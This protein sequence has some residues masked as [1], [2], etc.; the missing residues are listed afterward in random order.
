MSRAPLLL[1]II[2]L[3]LLLVA[4]PFGLLFFNHYHTV[5]P[6]RAIILGG[7][8]ILNLAAIWISFF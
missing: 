4:F 1:I 7:D 5:L 8:F 3:W 2:R 6:T